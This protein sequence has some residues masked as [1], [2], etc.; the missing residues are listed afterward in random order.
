MLRC[1]DRRHDWLLHWQKLKRKTN[2]SIYT[3]AI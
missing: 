3:L 1:N 2:V